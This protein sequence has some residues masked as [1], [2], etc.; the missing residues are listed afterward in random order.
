[1]TYFKRLSLKKKLVGLCIFMTMVSS[2]IGLV[3]YIGFHRVDSIFNQIIESVVPKLEKANTMFAEYR[4]VRIT[5]RT[6]G[7]P[8]IDEAQIESSIQGAYEA[9]AA[10]EKANEEYKALGF[11][12]GQKELYDKM[13]ASWLVFKSIGEKVIAL[14][15]SGKP[16][17]HEAMIKIFFTS[18][19][20]AA[21]EFTDDMKELLAFHKNTSDTYNKEAKGEAYQ[22]NILIL[23]IGAAGIL[24]ILTL[25]VT[26]AAVI[27]QT[28]T[29]ITEDLSKNAELVSSASEQIAAS[30]EQLSQAATEQ[31]S[32]LQE[33]ATSLDQ[34]SAMI[35]K[36]SESAE[37]AA[38]SSS[39]SQHKVVEG[40]QAVDQMLNSMSEISQSNDSI[41]GQINDSNQKMS[42]IVKVIQ[43][44]GQKT[45]VINEIV[46][47]TKL[48]SFNASVEAARAGESGKGFAV[49]AE[50]VG[51]LAQL[52]GN[53]AKAISDM[54][55]TS[56]SKVENIVTETKTKVDQLARQGQQ[57]IDTGVS[58]ANRCANVLNDIVKNVDKVSYL[59]KE[60][61]QASREQSHGVIEINK[62]MGQLDTV[63]QHNASASGQAANAGEQLSTQAHS[64]KEAVGHLIL[65]V[66]GENTTLHR[67]VKVS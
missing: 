13:Q 62:A 6:L 55:D 34:I 30:S 11:M 1:M 57:K 20:A 65:T 38:V 42:E 59:A 36:A 3:S 17:D 54:L 24:L 39:E 7:L 43:E 8:G 16:E 35:T 53:A 51:N 37:A 28:I 41:M 21:K 48:L 32:S 2:S 23:V 5:L 10:Y 40:K 47:Q 29:R 19:P 18:C 56:I 64:L 63:T 44:I 9:I 52:S 50:E 45:K 27:S 12:S 31:A 14:Q 46:F 15:R 22:V 49:V 61:S 58:V 67:N 33:T 66:Q 25:G 4:R 60:I 26:F